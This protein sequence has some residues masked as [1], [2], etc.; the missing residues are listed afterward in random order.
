MDHNDARRE[1]AASEVQRAL[2]LQPELPEAHLAMAWFHYQGHLDYESALRELAIAEQGL[3]GDADLLFARSVIYTR[4]GRLDQA[5]PSWE[6]AVELDPRNPNLLRQFASVLTRLR[7]YAMAEQYLDRVIEIAPDAVEA[8]MQKSMIPWLRDGD[9]TAHLQA[10]KGN[11]LLR[12]GE[13]LLSE[14]FI[15]I[16]RREYDLA[17]SALTESDM[18][19]MEDSR[20]W[21][22]PRTLLYGVTYDLAGQRALAIEQFELARAQLEDVLAQRPEDPRVMFT[23]AEALAG[24]EQAEAATR[25]VL[26]AIEAMPAVVGASDAAEF[27]K[28]GAIRVLAR[29]GA[30]DAAVEQLDIYL[31]GPGFW[32]IEGLLPSPR[33]DPL[34]GDPRFTMLV[35]K[36]RRQ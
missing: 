14:W 30:V 7:N 1:K 21:Y 18:E 2:E 31:A 27:R 10:I 28:D 33:L 35:E 12:P 13:A 36:Y 26:Q 23:L 4:M 25:L 11:P 6:S 16:D 3:P 17:L 19:V 34:R 24:L 20:F 32:S 22:K 29:A 5:L 9:A 8:K 15:A